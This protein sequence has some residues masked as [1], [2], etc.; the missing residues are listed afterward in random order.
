MLKEIV[1][2]GLSK[3]FYLT[4]GTEAN[5]AALKI[6]RLYTKRHKVISRYRSYH[7]ATAASIAVTGDIRRLYVEGLHTVSGMIFAPDPYCYRCPFGLSY[8]DCG[9][10]CRIC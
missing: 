6:A 8:P 9:A 5:E 3:F 1:P 10:V 2:P 7:R 4:S